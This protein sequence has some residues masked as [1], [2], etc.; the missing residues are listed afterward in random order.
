MLYAEILLGKFIFPDDSSVNSQDYQPNSN[1]LVY[2]PEK[3]V[4]ACEAPY[5]DDLRKDYFKIDNKKLNFNLCDFALGC[6]FLFFEKFEFFWFL[7]LL[8]NF[9]ISSFFFEKFEIFWFLFLLIS[10][11]LEELGGIVA[12]RNKLVPIKAKKN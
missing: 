5:F 4:K 1:L 8:W 9:E 10:A 11:F 3:R 2:T 7:Q 12:L 6:I